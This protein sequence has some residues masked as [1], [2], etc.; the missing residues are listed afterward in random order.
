MVRLHWKRREQTVEWRSLQIWE[1]VAL[2]YHYKA[3]MR[4]WMI[5]VRG[6]SQQLKEK[7]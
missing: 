7:D 4:N 2:D 5:M 1:T 6:Q 3:N